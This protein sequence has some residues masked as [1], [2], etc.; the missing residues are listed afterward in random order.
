MCVAAI[1]VAIFT[2]RP[3]HEWVT[4]GIGTLT[5]AL[6][7][8]Y[9][10]RS[11]TAVN[12][13]FSVAIFVHLGLTLVLGPVGAAGGAIADAIGTSQRLRPGLFRAAFNIADYFLA[14]VGAWVVFREV[15]SLGRHP[16]VGA[17]AG[18]LAGITQET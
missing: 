17:V 3:P 16:L 9:S 7:S 4:F 8:A 2:V 5:I 6:I 12:T 15:S 13:S 18:L 1:A 10:V 11:L 14:N